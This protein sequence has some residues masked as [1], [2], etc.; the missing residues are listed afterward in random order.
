MASK[1]LSVLARQISALVDS[2]E[3]H[4]AAIAKIDATL[5]QIQKALGSP[6]PRGDTMAKTLVLRPTGRR[7]RRRFST[8]GED[9]ILT[10][11]KSAGTPT[12]KD[13]NQH[14]VKEGRAGSAANT[15]TK[16]VKLKKLK[17]IPLKGERGSTYAIGHS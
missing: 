5:D 14:W 10:F 1:G 16:L 6:S 3:S 13:I 4:V 9:S 15:V 17:R 11:V 12:T 8:S 7:K 2:R